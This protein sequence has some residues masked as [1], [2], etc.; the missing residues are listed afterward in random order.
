MSKT[1]VNLGSKKCKKNNNYALLL[2]RIQNLLL[3][4]IVDNPEK[5]LSNVDSEIRHDKST[6][7]F[8]KVITNI[9]LLFNI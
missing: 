7:I 6:Y 8:S 3:L 2:I 1:I 4:S 5:Y 9:I